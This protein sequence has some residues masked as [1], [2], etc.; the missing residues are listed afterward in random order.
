MFRF[1]SYFYACI[2]GDT[3]TTGNSSR[4]S[5]DLLWFLVGFGAAD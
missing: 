5:D 1:I 4:A 3:L 2:A